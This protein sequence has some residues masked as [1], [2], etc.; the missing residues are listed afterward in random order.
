LV[1]LLVVEPVASIPSRGVEA[2]IGLVDLESQDRGR[3]PYPVVGGAVHPSGQGIFRWWVIVPVV[4]VWRCC[5]VCAE[6]RR[7]GVCPD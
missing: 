5:L 6:W 2:I 4:T 1:A 7:D 3:A